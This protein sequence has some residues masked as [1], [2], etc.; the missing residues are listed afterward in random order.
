ME[1]A[2]KEG[3]SV[4]RVALAE[5]PQILDRENVDPVDRVAAMGS[6]DGVVDEFQADHVEFDTADGIDALLA[7]LL[8]KGMVR[9]PP[10][11]D[12]LANEL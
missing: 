8:R 10:N 6:V 11:F 9:R 4:L 12:E 3:D 7:L 2:F 1:F 5:H